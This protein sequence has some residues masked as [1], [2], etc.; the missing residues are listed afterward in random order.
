MKWLE[1]SERAAVLFAAIFA[2][3]PMWQYF[4]EAPD[5]KLGRSATF[6]LAFSACNEV[7]HVL[8]QDAAI[9][10][11]RMEAR[12]QLAVDAKKRLLKKLSDP[13]YL[14]TLQQTNSESAAFY[15]DPLGIH[16]REAIAKE[17][18]YI[19]KLNRRGGL[20]DAAITNSAQ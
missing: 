19:Q 6:V 20:S 16:W 9:S 3:F 12:R 14:K 2:I 13:E 10:A 5:R 11:E 7:R 1:I 8:E 17:C 18:E 15:I 4:N